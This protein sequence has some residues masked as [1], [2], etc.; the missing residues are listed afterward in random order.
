MDTHP[1]A[2]GLPPTN[3]HEGLT[4]CSCGG[5]GHVGSLHRPHGEQ[6][7]QRE[8]ETHKPSLEAGVSASCKSLPCTTQGILKDQPFD[9]PLALP[10]LKK[11]RT[12]PVPF[13]HQVVVVINMVQVHEVPQLMRVRRPASLWHH[14]SGKTASR[15]TRVDPV[16]VWFAF[17][18][19]TPSHVQRQ[20]ILASLPQPAQT[21]PANMLNVRAV[22]IVDLAPEVAQVSS[23][24]VPE[25]DRL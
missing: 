7:Q 17:E 10:W 22:H 23:L 2:P 5:S 4:V 24:L 14:C 11:T 13:V 20:R 12:G 3:L 6:T 9:S 8:K 18:L 16:D 15:P 1:T 19:N 25:A 21:L